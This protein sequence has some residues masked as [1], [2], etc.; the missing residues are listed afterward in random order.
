[1]TVVWKV[2]RPSMEWNGERDRTLKA[3]TCSKPTTS[4]WSGEPLNSAITAGS[5]CSTPPSR[6]NQQAVDSPSCMILQDLYHQQATEGNLIDHTTPPGLHPLSSETIPPARTGPADH[7]AN[8]TGTCTPE[9]T[10]SGMSTARHRRRSEI[11]LIAPTAGS[12]RAGA[13][14]LVGRRQDRDG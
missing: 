7:C 2:D 10:A 5:S 11:A 14:G 4:W 12:W 6:S 8:V 1:M 3:S 13:D 9:A